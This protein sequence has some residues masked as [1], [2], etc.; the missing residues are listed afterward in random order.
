M[1][2]TD[3]TCPKCGADIPLT[4]AVSHRLREQ[5]TAD[6]EQQRTQ[7][8]AALKRREEQLTAALAAREQRI[9]TERTA[10]QQRTQ[11]LHAEVNRQL[12]AERQKLLTEAA[13]QAEERLGTQMRDLQQQLADRQSKLQQAQ[14][15][16]LTL[17]QQQR[18]LEEAKQNLELDVARKLDA[19]R[20]RIADAARQQGA[21]AERLKLADKDNIIK[22]LHEQIAA[23][24]Q[25]AEQGSTQLQGETLELELEAQL[26]A[27][28]PTDDI[29]G[30]KKGQ[31]G[32]DIAQCIRTQGGGVCGTILWEAKRARHWSGDWPEKLKAD[33]REAKA[34][35]AV[36]VTTSPPD[37]LRGM[38]P[39]E[40]VWVCEPAF[41]PALAAALRQGLI[42]TAA[43]RVQQAGRAD[44]MAALYDHL[45]SVEFR[46]QIE[47]LVEAFLGLQEQLAAEQRAFAR[48]WTE[49]EQQLRKAIAHTAMLYG[50]IQGIAGREALP[51]IR[52]LALPASDAQ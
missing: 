46:Q 17:R 47:A 1:S 43:L 44:K 30:V 38:A 34:E 4:E 28:F 51:E 45:C 52:T 19:E 35:L 24:Q 50:G 21:E 37:G 7:L 49:R 20:Q 2:E 39:F 42:S 6:F 23:L 31:R 8:N 5:F 48:Q 25:R 22:G 40:G 41:A 9:E 12:T 29:T 18:A 33:Q 11:A 32:A 3:I 27:A 13:R 15:L 26:R 10:L 14:E 36:I 16:E